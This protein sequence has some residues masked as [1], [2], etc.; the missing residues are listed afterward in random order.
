MGDLRHN[1]TRLAELADFILKR[2]G[3]D[4]YFYCDSNGFVT[5]GIGTLVAKEDD[6]RRI[7]RTLPSTSRFRTTGV[8]VRRPMTWRPTGA[9][10][11]SGQGCP[12]GRTVTSL[13][14]G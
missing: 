4:P 1:R 7:A 6:A 12:N 9:G 2:E 10:Y 3:F 11:T 8:S 14:S 5:I 13:S